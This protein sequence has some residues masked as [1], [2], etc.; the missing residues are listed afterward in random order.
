MTK[1]S[2]KFLKINTKIHSIEKFQNGEKMLI[3]MEGKERMKENKKEKKVGD[4]FTLRN[5]K[6]L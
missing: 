3:K 2:Q 6:R 4:I 5:A 1:K